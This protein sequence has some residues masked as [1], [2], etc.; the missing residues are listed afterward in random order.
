M[1]MMVMLVALMAV[2]AV[3]ALLLVGCGRSSDPDTYAVTLT[4]PTNATIAVTNSGITLTAVEVDTVLNVTMTPAAGFQVTGT[5]TAPAPTA[6]AVNATTG[7]ASWTVTVTGATTIAIPAGVTIT[8]LPWSADLSTLTFREARTA[9]W[10]GG[11]PTT[12]FGLGATEAPVDVPGHHMTGANASERIAI[13]GTTITVTTSHLANFLVVNFGDM[14]ETLAALDTLELYMVMPGETPNVN[15]ATNIANVAGL[16]GAAITETGG[17]ENTIAN[18]YQAFSITG[19]TR[20]IEFI[21]EHDGIEFAFTLVINRD[22][23][24]AQD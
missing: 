15:I 19:A 24:P 6:W 1:K 11:E 13:T 14:F 20:T 8:P 3:P 16:P 10:V 7:V 4:Q 23:A 2:V 18:A 5:P 22:A 12:Y 21:G 9:T 17:W